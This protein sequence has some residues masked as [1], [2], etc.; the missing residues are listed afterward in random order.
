MNAVP[1]QTR[2]Q[3]LSPGTAGTEGRGLIVPGPTELTD[4]PPSGFCPVLGRADRV[5]LLVNPMAGSGKSRRL[6]DRLARVLQGH[7]FQVEIIGELS[8]AAEAAQQFHAAGQLRALV[9]LGG[10]GTAAALANGTTPGVPLAFFPAGTSNLVAR[11]LGYSAHVDRF[12]QGLIAGRYVRLDAG[13]AAGRLFLA[14][15]GCGFDAA[16]VQEVHARRAKSDCGNISYWSYFKPIVH[17]IRTYEYPEIH[18]EFDEPAA[19][20]KRPGGVVYSGRWVFVF[21]L[22]LYGWGVRFARGASGSDGWLD[23]YCFERGGFWAGI[24]YLAELILGWHHR[25]RECRWR[26]VRRLR[27]WSTSDV[28]YQLDGDP[29][30]RLPVEVQLV[31]A[32]VTVLLPPR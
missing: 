2:G 16:V 12:A 10:D 22:P 27:L 5:I 6:A 4:D 9:G 14:M 7:G 18:V 28:P 30:G 1:E 19:E 31:P 21:N 32:R 29:G 17:S 25:S 24:R 26:R 11:Q 8:E 15:L 13:C 3:E 23:L 20:C